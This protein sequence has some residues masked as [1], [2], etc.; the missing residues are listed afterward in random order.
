MRVLVVSESSEFLPLVRGAFKEPSA[1]YLTQIELEHRPPQDLRDYLYDPL[2]GDDCDGR[3]LRAFRALDLVL[4]QTSPSQPLPWQRS[5]AQV[6]G[7]I[8]QCVGSGMPCFLAGGA[9]LTLAHVIATRGELGRSLVRGSSAIELSVS[10][11]LSGEAALEPSTGAL[12]NRAN[13]LG[14]WVKASVN[15][16]LHLPRPLVRGAEV[17]VEV[18]K[19]FAHHYCLSGLPPSGFIAPRLNQWEV[20]DPCPGPLQAIAYS[21]PGGPSIVQLCP[22]VLG[23]TFPVTT[24]YPLT[25]SVMGNYVKWLGARLTGGLPLGPVP[26]GVLNPPRPISNRGRWVRVL[27]SG[28]YCATSHRE[29]SISATPVVQ[30]SA[31]ATAPTCDVPSTT[32]PL[33]AELRAF[34]RVEIRKMLHPDLDC[35]GLEMGSR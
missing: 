5:N 22:S 27:N 9:C 23:C 32:P 34:S 35:S 29:M 21:S 13:A 26:R 15:V 4:V 3:A 14:G 28:D 2:G 10:S 30:V 25:V 18:H 20:L 7:L 31:A 16:G 19:R 6:R 8:K 17:Q 33:T 1:H 24:R 12:Y 11:V